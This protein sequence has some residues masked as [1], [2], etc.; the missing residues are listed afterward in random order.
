MSLLS[1]IV[2]CDS[3]PLLR[4]IGE[5]NRIKKELFSAYWNQDHFS[6]N[7]LNVGDNLI[8]THPKANSLRIS[9]LSLK[10]CGECHL[11]VTRCSCYCEQL[12]KSFPFSCQSLLQIQW[13]QEMGDN[14]L[15][16]P[17]T[18]RVGL[19]Y[20]KAI[21][22]GPKYLLSK[23]EIK[24]TNQSFFLVCLAFCEPIFSLGN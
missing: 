23:R 14:G 8:E 22:W 2:I 13:N 9:L 4:L 10:S 3:L 21:I 12:F 19:V 20:T 6:Q 11:L 24:P 1:Y 18:E 16:Y 5:W 15:P 17:C 7:Q